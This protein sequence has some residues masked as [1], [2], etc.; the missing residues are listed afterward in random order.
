MFS[1]SNIFNIYLYV[2]CVVLRRA[3]LLVASGPLRIDLLSPQKPSDLWDL[4]ENF[5]STLETQMDKLNITVVI[6]L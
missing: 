3:A 2:F 5:K 1:H 4:K 6:V